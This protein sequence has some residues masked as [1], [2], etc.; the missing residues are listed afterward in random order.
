MIPIPPQILSLLSSPKVIGAI[1]AVIAALSLWTYVNFLQHQVA[2]LKENNV[3]MTV[4]LE[5]NAKALARVQQDYELVMALNSKMTEKIAEIELNAA[6]QKETLFREREGKRSLE[7][8]AIKA[9]SKIEYRVNKATAGVLRCLE[10]VS[11]AK[12]DEN[13]N[14]D[15]CVV[16]SS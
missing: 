10:L 11:G 9:T 1:V 3:K 12:A 16:P 2:T 8:L 14:V 4:A 6:K 7:Q 13:E 15:N 5:Q